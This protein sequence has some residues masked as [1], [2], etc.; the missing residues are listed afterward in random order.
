MPMPFE[1]EVPGTTNFWLIIFGLTA[2]VPI[3]IYLVLDGMGIDGRAVACMS[4][5]FVF[6]LSVPL[7]LLN[8]GV[9]DWWYRFYNR[10][11]ED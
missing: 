9:W 4:W 5:F 6:A 11:E 10:E 3:S 1:E 7:V 8:E 2:L